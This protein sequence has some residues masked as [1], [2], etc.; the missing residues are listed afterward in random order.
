MKKQ[1]FKTI[2]ISLILGVGLSL[3][4][5]IAKTSS[6]W[7]AENYEKALGI[8]GDWVTYILIVVPLLF[9]FVVVKVAISFLGD[10]YD[11]ATS[12]FNP[13]SELTKHIRKMTNLAD[14]K[15]SKNELNNYPTDEIEIKKI[16][17]KYVNKNAEFFTAIYEKKEFQNINNFDNVYFVVKRNI[18]K[19][20]F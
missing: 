14:D 16:V 9:R 19:K 5:P 20:P 7:F 18:W 10:E 11:E 3:I 15:I 6:I 12:S 1:N 8:Y 4:V 2:I 13:T 17:N